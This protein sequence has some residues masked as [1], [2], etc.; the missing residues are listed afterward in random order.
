M[1]RR[2]QV[3]VWLVALAVIIAHTPLPDPI[4]LALVL[5]AGAVAVWGIYSTPKE[6]P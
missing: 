5:A 6:K 3:G 1:T 4:V 2:Q